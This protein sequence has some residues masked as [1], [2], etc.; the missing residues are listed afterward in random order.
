MNELTFKL[1][2]DNG[3]LIQY[4]ILKLLQDDSKNIK[5]IIY[6]DNGNDLYASRYR[7]LNNEIFVEPILEDDEW[8][9]IEKNSTEVLDGQTF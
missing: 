1:A 5:Y 4:K 7:L 8:N 9:F 2:L 6:T 3:T